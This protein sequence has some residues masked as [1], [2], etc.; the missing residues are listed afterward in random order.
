MVRQRIPYEERVVHIRF[1]GQS[2][3]I[4]FATI[5]VGSRSSDQE[6]RLALARYLEIPVHK[7]AHYVVERHAN[8][9]YTVRPEAVFG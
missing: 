7:L 9:N 4:P 2:R 3:S 1:Q 8:G 6:I 5:D